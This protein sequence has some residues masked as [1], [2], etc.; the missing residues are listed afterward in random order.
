MHIFKY[1]NIIHLTSV[2]VYW[3]KCL[4]VL[5]FYK[6]KNKILPN[7]QRLEW[8]TFQYEWYHVTWLYLHVLGPAVKTLK[9]RKTVLYTLLNAKSTFVKAN[10]YTNNT[11]NTL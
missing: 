11:T 6:V 4:I 9:I 3:S 7:I 1:F 5:T 2:T 8:D 10:I